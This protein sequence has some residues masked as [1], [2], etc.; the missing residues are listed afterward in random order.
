M[1]AAFFFL[2]H[3]A[4][5]ALYAFGLAHFGT[6]ATLVTASLAMLAVG[7]WAATTLKRSNI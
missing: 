2:G 3:A 7:A 6:T 4:G 1:H 5:P